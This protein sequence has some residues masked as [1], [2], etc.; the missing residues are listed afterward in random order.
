[1]DLD[2]PNSLT[3]LTEIFDAGYS[4]SK[5]YTFLGHRPVISKNPLTY[6]RNYVWQ[7]YAQ[8]DERRRHIGSAIHHLFENRTVGSG[9]H[10][11]VGIWSPNRPGEFLTPGLAQSVRSMSTFNQNVCSLNWH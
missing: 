1:M 4:L 6:A 7:T 10:P 8:A 9:E 2:T 3:T 11:T 5:D